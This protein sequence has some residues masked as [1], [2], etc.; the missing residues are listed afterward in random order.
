MKKIVVFILMA[1]LTAFGGQLLKARPVS[2]GRALEIG[3]KLFAA[4]P[5]T[6]TGSSTVSI[7]WDGE[8]AGSTTRESPAFYVVARDGGGFVIVAG[9]DNVPPVLAFSQDGC[10][11]TKDMPAN[12]RWWM[13]RM[14]RYVRSTFMEEPG[15][16]DQWNLFLDTRSDASVPVLEENIVKLHDTPEWSQGYVSVNGVQDSYFNKKCPT[17]DGELTLTGCVATALGEILTYMSGIEGITMP[18]ASSGVI[19]SYTVGSGRTH[20]DFPYQFGT[21]TYN[22]SGLRT[23]DEFWDVYYADPDLVLNMCQLLADCGAAVHAQYGLS[24]TSASSSAVIGG[25]GEHFGFNKAAHEEFV[26]NYTPRQWTSMLKAELDK[27]PVF[28]SG[29]SDNY[30]GHAF[31]FDG[32]GTYEGKDVFHVN[33][34]WMGRCNG[35]YYYYHL[36][37]QTEGPSE[38]YADSG[39]SAIFDFYP[40]PESAYLSPVLS[41]FPRDPYAGFVI[42]ASPI[43]PGKSFRLEL[44]SLQNTGSVT[45]Q[46]AIRF[47]LENRNGDIRLFGA[48]INVEMVPGSFSPGF[49]FSTAIPWNYTISF[50]DRLSLF[51]VREGSFVKVNYPVNGTVIGEIPL[52]PAAF[53][54]ID[55]PYGIGDTMTLQLLNYDGLYAGTTWTFTDKD[56]IVTTVPQSAGDFQFTKAGKYKIDAAIAPSE[57]A[58]VVEHV[59]AYVTVQ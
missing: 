50:G 41:I 57:G 13:E 42:P 30:G 55:G 59:V 22:W 46:N 48:T 21:T 56:G 53:I 49:S 25:M 27:W 2:P 31:V 4:G 19:E 39:V 28:Y 11:E 32:Y 6:R 34:G 8:F 17:M 47:G 45:Y 35:F 58:D 15:V 16:R 7:V 9:N 52:Y 36:D 14:K 38:D 44:G 54:L 18:P 43:E 24:G 5:A 33:F 12:V 37:T 51:Y 26:A 29:Q 1:G 20:P 10:F 40:A 3:Q 23:L